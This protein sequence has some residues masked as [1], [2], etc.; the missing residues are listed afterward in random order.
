MPPKCRDREALRSCIRPET[1]GPGSSPK[2]DEV[3]AI[4][5]ITGGN[6][7]PKS[8]VVLVL[9]INFLIDLFRALKGAFI[10]DV[11]QSEGESFES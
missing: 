3:S 5:D 8:L 2:P 11:T 9:K 10:K 1:L 7:G 4:G 6:C